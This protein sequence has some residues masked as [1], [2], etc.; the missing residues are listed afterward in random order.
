VSGTGDYVSY[1]DAAWFR[2]TPPWGV[3]N[4]SAWFFY[5]PPSGGAYGLAYLSRA[6]CGA[7]H[8]WLDD[9][10][11][12]SFPNKTLICAKFYENFGQTYD[13]QKC[14]GLST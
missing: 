1:I 6:G 10:V 9:Y 2:V 11:K 5:I 12:R 14:V 13:G 3:C 7:V 4:Y 8:V